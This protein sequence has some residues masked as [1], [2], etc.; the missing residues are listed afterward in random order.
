MPDP[1]E[2]SVSSEETR[3]IDSSTQLILSIMMSR[4]VNTNKFNRNYNKSASFDQGHMIPKEEHVPLSPDSKE[5]SNSM[6]S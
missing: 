6:P 2:T 3:S 1:A 4:R 5:S